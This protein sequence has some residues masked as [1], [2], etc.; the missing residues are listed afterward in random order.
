MKCI[1]AINLGKKR[2]LSVG[3]QMVS[4]SQTRKSHG[5]HVAEAHDRFN[6]LVVSKIDLSSTAETQQDP[7][8][9]VISY[10]T[11]TSKW[12]ST[13]EAKH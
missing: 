6:P 1:L 2:G 5:T 9:P 7:L 12:T 4:P 10:K 13:Q 8:L 3:S 11:K